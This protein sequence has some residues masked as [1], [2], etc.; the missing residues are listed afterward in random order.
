MLADLDGVAYY[1]DPASP[2]RHLDQ[3]LTPCQD[4]GRAEHPTA[5]M[6]TIDDAATS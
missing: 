3:N 6:A 4:N 5:G 2:A 1:R